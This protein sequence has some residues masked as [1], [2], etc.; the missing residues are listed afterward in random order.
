MPNTLPKTDRHWRNR[1]SPALCLDRNAIERM[2]CRLNDFRRIATRRDHRAVD[3]LA[4]AVSY[5]R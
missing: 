1:F 3:C 5:R 4:A 2:C